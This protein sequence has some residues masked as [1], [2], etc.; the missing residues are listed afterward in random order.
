MQLERKAKPTQASTLEIRAF[1]IFIPPLHRHGK[2]L[3]P[4]RKARADLAATA[5]LDE[6]F[7]QRWKTGMVNYVIK[8]K[9]EDDI[10]SCKT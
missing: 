1:W 8:R 7:R 9:F 4:E 10:S 5:C 2:H 3:H 6:L